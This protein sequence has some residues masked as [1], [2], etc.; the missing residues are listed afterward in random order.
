MLTFSCS[1]CVPVGMSRRDEILDVELQ[2]LAPFVYHLYLISWDIMRD[3]EKS[4]YLDKIAPGSTSVHQA[5]MVCCNK[6]KTVFW[7]QEVD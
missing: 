5:E 4:I 6:C 1:E 3:H 7:F 2:M